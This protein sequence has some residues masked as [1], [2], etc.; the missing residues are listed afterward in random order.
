MKKKNILVVGSLNMD[1]TVS[2]KNIPKTGETVLGSNLRYVP[3]GKGANQVVA[4]AK[5]GDA[6]TMLGSVGS[7]SH[8]GMLVRNLRNEGVVVDHIQSPK[9]VSS[10]LA[11][12][13]VEES[14]KNNIVVIPGANEK[15]DIA[16]LEQHEEVFAM[17]DYILVQMEIPL[18]SVL[19]AVK[20]AK[21]FGAKVILNPAP[22]PDPSEI[23]SYILQY[24]DIITPNETE[25]Q[26]LTGWAGEFSLDQLKASANKLL[27]QGPSQVIVTLGGQG[28][29]LCE[30]GKDPLVLPPPDAEVVDTVAAGDCFN[31]A[32]VVALSEEK[33]LEEAIRFANYASTIAVTRKGAQ[34]SIPSRDEVE[35][36]IKELTDE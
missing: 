22:S 14:G 5:L 9:S 8:G 15:T 16:Y 27:E 21:Q 33:S 26:T 10:G 36:F 7:D 11:V 1:M 19:Y 4:C 32:L 35:E 29:A 23:I 30:S 12:I 17:C 28:A 2:L 25:L 13:Y 6:V 3:G 31:G 20:K 34:D 18:E 24:V